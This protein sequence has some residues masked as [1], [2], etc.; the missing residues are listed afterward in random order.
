M[1][2][3]EKKPENDEN[4]QYKLPEEEKNEGE[5]PVEKEENEVKTEDSEVQENTESE[6]EPELEVKEI[7]TEEPK[8]ETVLSP[9]KKEG[10]FKPIIFIMIASMAIA[11]FWDKISFIKNAVHAALDPS[12]GALLNWNLNVG[13]ILIVLIISLFTTIIQKYATDQKQLKELRKEQ[14]IL[15][16]E[17]KKYKEHP[18]K[19]AELSKKQFAFFPKTFKLTSRAML[20]TGIPFILFFRWFN[21]F[22]IAMEAVTGAPIRFFGILS[23]FWFYL[24]LTMIFSTLL[25]KW[26]KVV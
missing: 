6:K 10:S 22:F 4:P 8:I 5:T 7:K 14:K 12:A 26:M 16:E 15:Q 20:F 19:M 13:M 11:I 2:E 1:D 21:D 23:W 17:M 24:I 25:R 9:K 3:L 18:E